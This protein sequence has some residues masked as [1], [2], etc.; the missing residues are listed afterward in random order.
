MSIVSAMSL[1]QLQTTLHLLQEMEGDGLTSLVGIREKLATEI[2]IQRRGL[3]SVKKGQTHLTPPERTNCPHCGE[4]MITI[5]ADDADGQSLVL[6]CQKC[7]YSRL[8][9]E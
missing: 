4:L 5:M 8:V 2:T 7:R 3:R 9:V 1:G 6:Q